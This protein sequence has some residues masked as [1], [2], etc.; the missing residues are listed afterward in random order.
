MEI[1]YVILFMALLAA[2]LVG[3]LKLLSWWEAYPH[4]WEYRNPY[5]RTCKICGR[6]EEEECWPDEF[7][8]Y[9]MRAR[10]WWEVYRE[11]DPQ[12]HEKRI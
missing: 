1:I 12:K 10:G 7:H 8:R 9:G 4:K 3:G 11:G 5:C 6:H 2:L